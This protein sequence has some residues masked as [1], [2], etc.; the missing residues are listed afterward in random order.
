M[1]ASFF[2]RGL[3]DMTTS[4]NREI[5]TRML[6]AL[7]SKEFDIFEQLLADDLVCEWPFAVMEG[8]PS[9]M[10]G[11]RKLREALEV[12]FRTFTPYNFRILEIH[13]LT[14]PD[15][16]IAEYSS[17]STYLPRN[18]PYSN[19]YIAVVDFRGGRVSAWREYLNPL[20]IGEALGR[21][22]FWE[23]TQGAV[24]RSE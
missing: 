1:P 11:A 4:S 12:S 5:F 24:K 10:V 23:L 7:G 17:H 18:V 13:D 15:R 16:L 3:S 8:F 19:R 2:D 20:P 22:F 6:T 9:K 21:D 14:A